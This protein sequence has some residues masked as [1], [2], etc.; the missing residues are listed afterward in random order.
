[1]YQF[2]LYSIVTQS[3]IYIY[4]FF[5]SHCLPAGPHCLSI[6]N[7]CQGGRGREWDGQGVWVGRC[8][9]AFIT[10]LGTWVPAGL[11]ASTIRRGPL[12]RRTWSTPSTG[13][14]I[15]QG[16]HWALRTQEREGMREEGEV[17]C[18]H[19]LT[20]R[21]PPLNSQWK[22]TSH[23]CPDHRPSHHGSCFP[24]GSRDPLQS[25]KIIQVCT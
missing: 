3:Y 23:F 5:F 9:H 2:L 13:V 14:S 20:W 17:F 21:R 15:I 18:S 6:L 7:S 1:M 24:Q 22:P 25:L 10:P 12:L 4:A 11:S 8:T 16:T 19:W